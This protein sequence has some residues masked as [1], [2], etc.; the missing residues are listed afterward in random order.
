MRL[1]AVV[2]EHPDL[3]LL[4]VNM[5]D[6]TGFEACSKIRMSFGGPI[7]MVTVRDEE[8]DKVVD[9]VTAVRGTAKMREAGPHEL[10]LLHR[11]QKLFSYESTHRRETRLDGFALRRGQVR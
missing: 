3:I 11:G 10:I 5:P 9:P 4:D 1:F 6:M 8:Q 7:I 2:R